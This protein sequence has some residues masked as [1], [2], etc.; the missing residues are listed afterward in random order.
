M[1]IAA[2]TGM[3]VAAAF[4]PTGVA[5]DAREGRHRV[6]I[7]RFTFVP[8]RLVVAPGDIVVWVNH[9]LVP[10]TVTAEDGGWD[11]QE[12]APNDKWELRV[13]EEM[14]GDYFCRYHPMMRGRV[15]VRRR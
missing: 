15:H 3:V 9:D 7:Q 2:V 12:L 1:G 13:T 8:D 11:S 10:H 6:D 14:T 5:Q 4:A